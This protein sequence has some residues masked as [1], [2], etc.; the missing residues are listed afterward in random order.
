MTAT[1]KMRKK[2]KRKKKMN[3]MKRVNQPQSL[4]STNK[5]ILN[6][7]KPQFVLRHPM[8]L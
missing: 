8:M 2:K 4:S 6:Q 5:K 3:K 7:N 1:V